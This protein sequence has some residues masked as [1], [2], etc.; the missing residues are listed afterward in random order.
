MEGKDILHNILILKKIFFPQLIPGL[1]LGSFT[2]QNISSL[3]IIHTSVYWLKKYILYLV[4]I[5]KNAFFILICIFNNLFIPWWALFTSFSLC[6]EASCN[7]SYNDMRNTLPQAG[8]W[9]SYW[10]YTGLRGTTCLS[11]TVLCIS[12]YINLKKK[13]NTYIYILSKFY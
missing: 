11:G 1:K 3:A 8:S 9:R 6:K 12:L 2:L 5:H 4:Y 7:L 13:L 10:V